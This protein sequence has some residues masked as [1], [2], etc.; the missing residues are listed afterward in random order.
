MVSWI[1]WLSD[2]MDSE[3]AFPG[4]Q[5]RLRVERMWIRTRGQ[6]DCISGAHAFFRHHEIA[7]RGLIEWPCGFP[8][9]SFF[10]RAWFFF[11]FLCFFLLFVL[12]FRFSISWFCFFFA[13]GQLVSQHR[14]NCDRRIVVGRCFASASILQRWSTWPRLPCRALQG[15]I[16][17]IV[18]YG[19]S[20]KGVGPY[21][22]VR[23]RCMT[24][25][26]PND[27][28]LAQGRPSL[29]ELDADLPASQT[30]ISTAFRQDSSCHLPLYLTTQD[31]HLTLHVRSVATGVFPPNVIT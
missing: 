7:K 26:H 14:P 1:V 19:A 28:G 13:A 24:H 20:H 17:N 21:M 25:H 30:R 10:F 31:Y 6:S 27:S 9:G 15:G 23:L 11:A 12:C 5:S 29:F 18:P 4:G 3:Q 2:L 22:V 8:V 16:R